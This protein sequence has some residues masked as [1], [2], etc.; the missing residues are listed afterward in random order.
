MQN[1]SK[2]CIVVLGMHRSG[3]SSLTRLISFAG[4]KLPKTLIETRHGNESG[5]WES[6]KIVNFTQGFLVSFYK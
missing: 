3:T 6:S 5:H 2:K 4:A 1:H